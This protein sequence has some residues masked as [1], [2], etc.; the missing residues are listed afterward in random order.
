MDESYIFPCAPKQSIVSLSAGST[1]DGSNT[2][3]G[4][5]RNS[6]IYGTSL[7]GIIQ[8][9]FPSMNPI[10]DIAQLGQVSCSHLV[11]GYPLTYSPNSWFDWHPNLLKF[12]SI[13]EIIQ[14]GGF[15]PL[16]LWRFWGGSITQSRQQISHSQSYVQLHRSVGKCPHR[17]KHQS[18]YDYTMLE[19]Q[20]DTTNNKMNDSSFMFITTTAGTVS[21]ANHEF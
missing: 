19:K 18:L 21:I 14:S 15:L 5:R 11:N 20:T 10:F 13:L 3:W 12:I 16:R 17:S 9:I 6:D 1:S 2:G 8:L 7:T 4:A